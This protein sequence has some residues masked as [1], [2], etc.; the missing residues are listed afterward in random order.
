MWLL[1]DIRSFDQGGRKGLTCVFILFCSFVFDRSC[2]L[3]ER[4]E[5]YVSYPD[6]S[7]LGILYIYADLF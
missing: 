4:R 6:L 3:F 5:M 7:S 2:R 1:T